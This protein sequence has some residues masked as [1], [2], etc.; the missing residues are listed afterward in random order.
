MIYNQHEYDIKLEWG[1]K[2][3]EE[4]SPVS[5]VI[6]I[7][8]VLSFSTCVDVVVNNEG[9]VFPYRWKD[10]TAVDFAKSKDAVLADPKRQYSNAYSLSPTSLLSVRKGEKIVLPSPNGSTLS[11]A[12]GGKTT[13]CGCLRNAKA[14]ADY[15]I[16]AGKKIALIPAGEQWTDKSLRP[17]FEDL[18]AA[19]AIASYLQG[20]LS[21]ES[22]TALSVYKDYRERLTEG[23][24]KCSSGKELTERG[25]TN[26]VL[27]AGELNVSQKVAVLIDNK[28][29][30]RWNH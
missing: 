20:T 22:E 12:T 15:A 2:G 17:C 14:V 10:S 21:P 23:L 1:L 18:L 16:T 19:G 29:V 11:L 24:L 13:L 8:D 25:F 6:I 3:V 9:S 4:L 27:L 7:I 28:Y 26:D 30:G 5:D